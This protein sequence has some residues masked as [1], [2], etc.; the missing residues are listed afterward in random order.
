MLGI[1]C[2]GEH[3][4]G[5]GLE[6]EIVDHCFVL[7]SNVGDGSRQ[8]EHHVEI[9]HRQ[10][11]R[12]ALGQPFLSGGGL[13][14][15]TVP[16]TA[17]VIGDDGVRTLLAALDAADR[18]SKKICTR[19]E[20]DNYIQGEDARSPY[21]SA[22]RE[23]MMKSKM[24]L[25]AAA[26]TFALIAS[27][28]IAKADTTFDISGTFAETAPGTTISGMISI[29]TVTGVVDAVPAPNITYSAGSPGPFTLLVASFSESAPAE[30][31]IFVGNP[32]GAFV[33]IDFTTPL[34]SPPNPGSLVGFNG[35]TIVSGLIFNSADQIV[36]QELSGSIVPH[37]ASVPG[38]IVG[39]GLP[40]LILA[41][42]GLLGWWR[43]RRIRNGSAALAVF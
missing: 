16:V 27:V 37:V 17:G 2:D 1:G 6:Q 35:G 30:W 9:W 32:S 33:R 28:G 23:V 42:G 40:G 10:Q 41:C 22:S 11:L 3:G 39:A 19:S 12:L 38:P 8:R 4:L 34:V 31:G 36:A 21:S 7:I 15:G 5:R 29:N 43:R 14:F 18:L 24:S 26:A 20:V 25:S 13:T